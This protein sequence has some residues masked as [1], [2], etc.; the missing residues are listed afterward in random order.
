MDIVVTLLLALPTI[1]LAA[2]LAAVLEN[3]RERLRTRKWVMRN[4]RELASAPT[5]LAPLQEA[6][7]AVQ[8]WLAAE[9][10]EDLT[11]LDWRRV[12]FGAF[13]NAPDLSPLVRSEA[14]I[15]VRPEVF[16]ALHQLDDQLTS[17]TRFETYLNDMFGRDIAPL[18]YERRVPLAG[19]DRHRVAWYAHL[20]ATYL[21]LTRQAH[22][23]LAE[24]RTAVGSR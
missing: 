17:L 8:G 19:A 14:A 7:T 1:F 20:L 13:S 15:S 10:P 12:W 23:A 3:T 24:F 9:S 16:A 6:E 22:Q 11:E 2:F 21:R 4:L 5:D 18:W